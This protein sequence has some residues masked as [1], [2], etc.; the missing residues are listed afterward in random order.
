VNVNSKNTITP[1]HDHDSLLERATG[2]YYRLCDRQGW[3]RQVPS[4]SLSV[5]SGSEVK[6]ANARG[7]LAC[8]HVTP[9]GRLHLVPG[10]TG[11]GAS[12]VTGG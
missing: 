9:S 10:S 11:G 4:I 2:A 1:R 8:Y 7:V 12:T 5:V 3:V 6:L